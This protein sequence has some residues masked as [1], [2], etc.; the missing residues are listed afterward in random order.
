MFRIALTA[1]PLAGCLY[2]EAD[3]PAPG[4]RNDGAPLFVYADAGCYPDEYYHDFVWYFDAD[5]DDP[6]GAID[7]VAVYADVYDTWDG[8]W[9]DGFELYPENGL[10]WFSAWIGDT[11][12]LNCDYP[13]YVVDLTAIDSW[14]ADTVATVSPD[15]W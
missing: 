3:P 13:G 4:P 8:S 9:V 12:W 10:T 14:D 15:T 2:Y 7:V 6:D 1:L 5:V 11:T